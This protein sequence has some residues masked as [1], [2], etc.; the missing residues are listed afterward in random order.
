MELATEKLKQN[1]KVNLH[2][3]VKAFRFV[4]Y[5]E[6]QGVSLPRRIRYLQNLT[7]LAS[8]LD[9]K[10]FEDVTKADLETI[11]LEAGRQDLSDETKV[12]FKVM[13]KRFYRW[14]KDPNDQ[15]YPPEVKW[16]K[17]TLKNNHHILPEELLTEE[18]VKQLIQAGGWSRDKAFVSMLYDS[19]GRIGE[20][21]TLQR[22][23]VSFDQY[24]AV[25]LVD[26]KTGQR[27]DRLILS[28]PFVADWLNDHPDKT[29]DAPLWIHSKQGCHE[30]GTVPMDYYSA[31]MLLQRLKTRSGINKAVNPHAF[32]HARATH[33]ASHL[34]EA[35]MKQVFGWT[36][37]S[38]M[39]GR[40]VHLSG[41]DVDGALLEAAGI[42]TTT[43]TEPQPPK[44]T[45]VNCARCDQQNS[46]INKFCNHCGMPLDLK[47]AVEVDAKRTQS[48]D[49]M[50]I[51]M[52]DKDVQKMMSKKIKEYGL[53]ELIH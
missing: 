29:P 48:D 31:R 41:R 14:L 33:L 45:V 1:R 36:Q 12:L 43:R 34:T 26:G 51:L 7:K 24:G 49:W 23:N 13:L 39:A 19:G 32:R 53:T 27:R 21:L 10:D 52:G 4:E 30:K 38:R 47:T 46:T 25:V 37:D 11:L 40:Y 17:T 3:R 44:L 15:E 9:K 35:Q 18:E 22:K 2:N 20:I 28:V 42:E 5:L 50:T 16:I 8:I 6:T